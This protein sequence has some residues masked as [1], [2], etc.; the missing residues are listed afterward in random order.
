MSTNSTY[1]AD[2]NLHD[3][4]TNILKTNIDNHS[5]DS[6]EEHN[7]H[8]HGNDKESLLSPKTKQIHTPKSEDNKKLYHDK[9]GAVSPLVER[10]KKKLIAAVV[11]TFIFMILEF[12]GGI[13][14][15]SLAIMTD[16][17]HLLT[18][19][20]AI[21]ISLIAIWVS[22]F[23]ANSK[24]TFGYHRVEVIGVLI[25]VLLIWIVTAALILEA[26]H[27]LQNPQSVNGQLMFIISV[28]G[29]VVNI[30][31]GKVLHQGP[32]AEILGHNHNHNHDHHD[33]HDEENGH[34]HHH[35]FNL[36][37]SAAF[38][39]VLGDLIQNIGVMIAAIIIWAK[40]EWY[41]ADPIC[42]FL[43]SILVAF[44]TIGLLRRSFN[45]FMDTCPEDI[46]CEK[47]KI[48]VLNIQDVKTISDLHIWSISSGK[49]LL[50]MS[51]IIG[52]EADSEAVLIKL[53][54]MLIT[55]Y[56]IHHS[57][58]QLI[59]YQHSVGVYSD[60]CNGGLHS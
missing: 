34:H 22:H 37:V 6:D 21:V 4:V 12:G 38:I 17:A 8:S 48:N 30:V 20:L 19:A 26:I 3:A 44:T 47:V 33:E 60:Q 46:D 57:T 55:N 32:V 29:L 25:S 1:Q 2:A 18:D 36:N 11:I 43:F 51:A 49:V 9:F 24:Y 39:H 40:P 5:D 59:R 45:I 16:A 10:S 35:K 56:G 13:I 28:I 31:L 52:P 23:P 50:C 41:I 58:I 54:K 7:H 15:N 42:T 27:R 53:Q 14:A